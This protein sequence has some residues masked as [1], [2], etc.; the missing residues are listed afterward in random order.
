MTTTDPAPVTA[1]VQPET[2][3]PGREWTLA[4][5]ESQGLHPEKLAKALAWLKSRC[6]RQGV[7]QAL[8]VRNG[9]L[10]WQGADIDHSHDVWS[11]TKTFTSLVLGLL[12]DDGLVS[13][14]D[15][16]QDFVPGLRFNYPEA[17]LRH[18]VTMTSGYDAIGGDQSKSP[19]YP[20]FPLFYPPGS[21][22]EY[23]DAATNQLANILTQ[24]AGQSLAELFGTRIAAPIG[25]PPGRWSWGHWGSIHWKR[26]N[27][28]AGNKGKGIAISARELARLGLLLLGRGRWN[29]RRLLSADWIEAATRNQVDRG[30]PW[31]GERA[32]VAGCYGFNLWINGIG[33]NGR[34]KWPGAPEGTHAMSGFNNNH[35]FVVP[36]WNLVLV[37]LGTDGSVEDAVYGDFFSRLAGAVQD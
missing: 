16:A 25:M 32:D 17:T 11:C 15:L 4:P 22:N 7:S 14:D 1:G 2:V 19:F 9:Y 3:F 33:R 28:G 5:P 31:H 30:I 37:R 10:V 35:C 34:R 29:G 20:S 24:A 12:V 6:G 36:E 18:F 23:W 26:V 8:V 13:L 27:G 21:S